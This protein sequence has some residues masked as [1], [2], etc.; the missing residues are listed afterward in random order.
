MR[1]AGEVADQ[2]GLSSAAT[3]VIQTAMTM[4]S[5]PGVTTA[6]GPEAYLLAAG[7]AVDVA[8]VRS[9]ELPPQTL[10][11]ALRDY[12]RAVRVPKGRARFVNRYG[13]L[14]TAIKLAPFD[15]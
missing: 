6:A 5:T 3:E 7:A 14:S 12:P 2:V 13:A 9:W 11:N 8:G 1:L 15:E 4:H 10:P